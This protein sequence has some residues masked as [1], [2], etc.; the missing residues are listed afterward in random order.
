MS[1]KLIRPNASRWDLDQSIFDW[2][3]HAEGLLNAYGRWG[4]LA[5]KIGEPVLVNVIQY[6]AKNCEFTNQPADKEFFMAAVEAYCKRSMTSL[7]RLIA[8]LDKKE[9]LEYRANN[10]NN[11]GGSVYR[12]STAEVREER[13][14]A[15]GQI[16][17]SSPSQ[18]MTVADFLGVQQR[19][20]V[21][22]APDANGKR[23][24]SRQ[25]ATDWMLSKHPDELEFWEDFFQYHGQSGSGDQLYI[26]K[27]R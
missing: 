1:F 13:R 14:H 3:E 17:S 9:P 4:R 2:Y 25:Q 12:N 6:Y 7:D 21:A 26:L 11:T 16:R 24:F 15:A 8:M 20:A 27:Q 5:G 22:T 10:P 19:P 23:V 18:T